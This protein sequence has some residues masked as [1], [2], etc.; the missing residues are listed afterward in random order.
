MKNYTRVSSIN[1]PKPD[2]RGQRDIRVTVQPVRLPRAPAAQ[3][4]KGARNPWK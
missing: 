3:N 2:R 4:K 1:E